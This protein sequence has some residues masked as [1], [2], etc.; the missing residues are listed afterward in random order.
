MCFTVKYITQKKLK[1]AKRRGDSPE[2]ID[3]IERDLN[4]LTLN[5]EAQEASS[6]FA[7][8]PLLVFRNVNPLT[9][10]LFYWG[11][12]P[13][14]VKDEQQATQIQ[15]KTLN[16]RGETIFEKPSFRKAAQFQRCLIMIDGF[17][18]YHHSKGK[19]YPYLLEYADKSP[20]V[21]AGLWDRCK[22]VEGVVWETV[23][24]V[25]TKAEGL[26]KEIHNNPKRKE[27]RTPVILRKKDERIW[28]RDNCSANELS[29]LIKEGNGRDLMATQ[30]PP[31]NSN[32]K[33]N[34][35]KNTLF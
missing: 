27:S 12:V 6:G 15:N 11:L 20:M 34:T 21:L 29:Q 17:Y 16:A 32:F 31:L 3:R 25:T 9:P 30:V 5:M 1:Y 24:I 26:V 4:D 33:S 35:Q 18:D 23:S 28:L 22:T 2:E 19:A 8:P 7:H 10:E 14:W 13:F